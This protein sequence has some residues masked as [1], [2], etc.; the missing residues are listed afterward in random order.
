MWVLSKVQQMELLYRIMELGLNFTF[1][2]LVSMQPLALP[3]QWN[4]C[5]T[6]REEQL[7][8]PLYQRILRQNL[9]NK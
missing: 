3:E 2:F 4:L 1:S 8:V 5:T 7:C 9:P 6:V